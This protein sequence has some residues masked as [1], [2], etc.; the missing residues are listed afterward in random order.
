MYKRISVH[1]VEFTSG[2]THGKIYSRGGC[3]YSDSGDC[4]GSGGD[5]SGSGALV[6]GVDEI[7]IVVIRVHVVGV[8][9]GN[10]CFSSVYLW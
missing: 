10:L 4:S 1:Q 2:I 7:H 8:L 3:N 9:G 6:G 5:C